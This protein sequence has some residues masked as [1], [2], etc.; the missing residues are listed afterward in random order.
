MS[1]I[2]RHGLMLL[3]IVAALGQL[4]VSTASILAA[5]GGLLLAISLALQGTL[6]NV[7][8]GVM[9]LW[10][11]PFRVGDYIEA[12]GLAGTV[13]EV[14]LFATRIDTLEEL[15]RFVPNSELWNKPIL[16]YTR[17]PSRMMNVNIGISYDSSVDK[18]RSIML[19]LCQE[20]ERV[21]D[22]PEPLVF[23]ADYADSAV[24]LTWRAWIPTAQYWPTHRAL[25]EA[26]K[27]RFDEEGVEIPFPQ[28]V[29]HIEGGN[30]PTPE[31]A[32]A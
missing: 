10:L 23:V 32:A 29:L 14:G 30:P 22:I 19:A 17:N 6:S 3:V 9:L 11:R 28:R 12:G 13:R 25:V 18:A 24:V 20:D 4:G 2:V 7:A 1:G 5:L 27:K 15:Y 21:L 26:A 31:Q 16:N 8:A